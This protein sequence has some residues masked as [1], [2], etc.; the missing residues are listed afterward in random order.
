MKTDIEIAREI[1]L[2][3]IDEICKDLEVENYDQYGKY[4]AKLDLS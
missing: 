3:D 4:K 1:E 2:K